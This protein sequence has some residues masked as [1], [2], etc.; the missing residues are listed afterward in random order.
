VA[1]PSFTR[2][3][4]CLLSAAFGAALYGQS[5]ADHHKNK[6]EPVTQEPPEEDVS[7]L[8]KEYAL[9][10]LQAEKEYRVG[11]YYL[12]KG[13]VKAAARRFEEATKWNPGYAEAYARLG[14]ALS[15]LRDEKAAH[16][17][18]K[19][20]LELQPEGKEAAAVRKKLGKS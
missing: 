14:D 17:A 8:P 5:Q 9:N 2:L 4:R 19:K 18:Y 10:P 12:K 13:T 11:L 7:S 1:S 3:K 20:Y 16:E 15:R 6:Q